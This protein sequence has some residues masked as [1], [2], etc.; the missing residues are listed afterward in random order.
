VPPVDREDRGARRLDVFGLV[1]GRLRDLR[2]QH[3]AE[4]PARGRGQDGDEL[5]DPVLEQTLRLADGPGDCS[6][7]AIRIA[8]DAQWRMSIGDAYAVAALLSN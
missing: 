6:G 7:S 4:L 2:R 1:A 8:A 3:V 5:Y